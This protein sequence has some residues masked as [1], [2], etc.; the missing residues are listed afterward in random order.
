M[1]P[2]KYIFTGFGL[3]IASALTACAAPNQTTE[4]GVGM[5]EMTQPGPQAIRKETAEKADPK[6]RSANYEITFHNFSNHTI[7]VTQND[8]SCMKNVGDKFF[9]IGPNGY[10]GMNIEDSNNAFSNCTDNPKK[11]QWSVSD[12]GVVIFEHARWT[13]FNGWGTTFYVSGNTQGHCGSSNGIDCTYPN[14]AGNQYVGLDVY[15]R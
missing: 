10:H 5:S 7:Y 4:T 11:I 9:S 2:E 1:N 14:I 6:N 12:R 13:N 15:L 8:S 3:L